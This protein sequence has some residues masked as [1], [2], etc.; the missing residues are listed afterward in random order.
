MHFSVALR[1]LAFAVAACA[2]LAVASGYPAMAADVNGAAARVEES[3]GIL[4]PLK[5]M[6]SKAAESAI[7][8]FG[9]GR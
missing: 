9:G 2:L 5:D 3:R 6:A 1:V 4:D 7:R 8:L